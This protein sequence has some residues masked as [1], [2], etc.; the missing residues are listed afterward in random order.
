MN[1]TEKKNNKQDMDYSYR[2]SNKSINNYQR[3]KYEE[4]RENYIIEIKSYATKNR[5]R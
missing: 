1:N 5:C 3:A 4:K 2:R